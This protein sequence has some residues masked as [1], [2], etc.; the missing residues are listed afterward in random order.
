M[1]ELEQRKSKI[2]NNIKYDYNSYLQTDFLTGAP[3][4]ITTPSNKALIVS[5]PTVLRK[6]KTKSI[7][8]H[9]SQK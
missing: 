9:L 3:Q 2:E 8:M 7:S 1:N 6:T 4:R 5:Q